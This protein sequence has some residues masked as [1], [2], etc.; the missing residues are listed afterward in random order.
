MEIT[1]PGISMLISAI[2][3]AAAVYLKYRRKK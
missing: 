1:L 2:T 3:G